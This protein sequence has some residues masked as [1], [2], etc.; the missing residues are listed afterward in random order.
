MYE[1]SIIHPKQITRINKDT[2]IIK[3]FE[4]GTIYVFDEFIK[5]GE[6]YFRINDNFAFFITIHIILLIFLSVKKKQIK[7]CQKVISQFQNL[8]KFIPYHIVRN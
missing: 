1:N 5:S 2:G 8:R 3:V 6:K 4:P 7:I